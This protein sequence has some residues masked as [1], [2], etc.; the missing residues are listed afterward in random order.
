MGKCVL[1]AGLFSC[2]SN[3]PFH[4]DLSFESE[5]QGNSEMAYKAVF[6]NLRLIAFCVMQVMLSHNLARGL[7]PRNLKDNF[8]AHYNIKLSFV[9]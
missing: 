3:S 1:P 7:P 9:P 8:H 5:A 4:K 2:K 6:A